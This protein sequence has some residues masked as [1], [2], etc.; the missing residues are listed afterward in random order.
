MQIFLNSFSRNIKRNEH[1]LLILDG[2][3]AHDNN[4]IIIPKNITLH[5]LPPYSPQLNPIERLWCYLKRNYLSFKLYEKM[6][7]IIQT[8]SDAWNKLTDGIIKSIGISQPSKQ[9]SE[10]VR[11]IPSPGQANRCVSQREQ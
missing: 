8:G 4:K 9:D 5:F 3:R 1:V 2:S 7:D 11:H 6:D 10:C